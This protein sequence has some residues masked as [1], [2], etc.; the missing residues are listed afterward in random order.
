VLEFDGGVRCMMMRGG[1]SR[2]AY[3]LAD[4]LPSDTR[5]RD[6]LL[7]RIMGSPNELQVDGIGGGH[8]LTSKVAVVSRSTDPQIDVDYL[9]LQVSVT[10]AE[11]TDRQNCGNILAGIA[12]FAIERGLVAAVD[13]TTTVRIR[14]MNTGSIAVA[15]VSTPGARVS[16]DG[17][18]AIDGVG[19]SSAAIPLTLVDVAGSSTGSLLPTGRVVDL[20][21]GLSVTC[22]DNG[23]PSLLVAA[24][25]LGVDG[26]ESPQ[27]LEAR[28]DL[29]A[30][31]VEIRRQGA[32]LMGIDDIGSTTVPKVV[33]LLPPVNGGAIGTRSFLPVRCHHS[34]GVLGATTVAAGIQ[35]EGAVGHDIAVLPPTGDT[36]RIE[37]PSGY[38]DVGVTVART[39]EGVTALDSTVLRTARK[40]FD[41]YV[42]ARPA[43]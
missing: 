36:L 26:T 15:A 34:I 8:P 24:A 18:F 14:M 40:L 17:D 39:A 33:L 5:A 3:F 28:E 11:V 21:D 4:D 35:L 38:L 12:P 23:M 19:G 42:F 9:F 25:D 22:V 43:L 1:T 7:V 37:H 29:A 6:D 41:G 27:Q 20:V 10:S 31:L 2:G 13:G 16:Y 30:R 32:A